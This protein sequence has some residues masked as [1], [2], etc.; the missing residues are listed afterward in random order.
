MITGIP[1]NRVLTAIVGILL[2]APLPLRAQD[3][4]TDF[5]RDW[6]FSKGEQPEAARELSFD[7]SSWQPVRLPH[8]WAISGPFD[9]KA[10][11]ST[12]KLPWQ[13]VGWYRKKF[14]V[15][16][17]EGQRVYF[18]F[19][20]VMAFPKVYVNG[21][22]AGEWDYGY[23]SFRVDTT[24]LIR[25][26]Q[27][28]VIA[29]EADTRRHRSRWYPGAGIYRKVQMTITEP[30]HFAHWG[31][32]VTTPAVSDRRA[33]IRVRSTIENHE[34]TDQEVT[35]EVSILD[36][37]G[38]SVSTSKKR[39]TVPAGGSAEVDQQMF[40]PDP[41]RWDIDHPNLYRA[42]ATIRV[43]DKTLGSQ[44]VTF[45]IRTFSFDANRGFFLNG[46]RV[47]L[48]GVDL[49]HDLGALG[50]AFNRRA[51]QRQLEI[52]KEMG[53]N[54]LRTSH[55]APAP[56]VLE[57]CDQ[58]GIFVWDECFDKWDAT[59]DNLG[60]PANVLPMA[61]RQL[62]NFVR[63]DRNHPCVFV[64][65]VGNEI[66]TSVDERGDG[67]S[68]G[69]LA[70]MRDAVRTQDDTRPVGI[71]CHTPNTVNYP[72]YDPLDLTGWNYG[73]RYARYREAYPDKPILYSESS[74]TVSTRGYYSLPLPESKTDYPGGTEHVS[75]YDLSATPW[76]DIPD[77]EFKLME[78]DRFVGGEFV[79]TGFDYL[80]EP[81]PNRRTARSSYFG[82]VDLAGIP[83]DRY[84]L[85]RS[86]WRPD[87]QT[88]HILPHWNWPERVGKKV[89]VFVYTDGDSGELFL[90]GKSLG[91][92]TKGVVPPKPKKDYYDV[93]YQYRLR[94]NDV[95]Y[96]PGEL[97]VVVY[98]KG[99]KVGEEV[100]RT[101]GPPASIRLTPDRTKLL[102]DGEDLSFILVEAMDAQGNPAPLADNMIE[103]EVAGAGE[104]AAADNGDQLSLESFQ[105]NHHALFN[106]KAMLIVRTKDSQ[107][108]P[109]RV[110]A[111]S[112]GLKPAT[113]SLQTMT[114]AHG[115]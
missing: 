5:N 102:A 68:F 44:T 81:T 109:I 58:M 110:T 55:N 1:V 65:S 22:L 72:V 100:M 61:V 111:R 62:N 53:V 106:G 20:G 48:H 46:R 112:A 40:V 96:E 37:K 92:R 74:S 10:S 26:G 33:T 90:N 12:G 77:V 57:L 36:P 56:E 24:P 108:G 14:T 11:G 7:D 25:F 76:S 88:I 85:Y 15:E 64:W 83:K 69:R 93:T 13:G 101:A 32:F 41:Q 38:S 104:L 49:H 17:H 95:I 84:Y 67:M 94:W 105:S 3:A 27:Q 80:G 42:V 87:V 52:M 79:W 31:I 91:M 47:Q 23:M 29:V 113:V 50:A 45:G 86:H 39:G 107:V 16:G 75:S 28:N 78:D 103:F 4:V 89:P 18:D 115:N 99:V 9:A 82:I 66:G 98:K 19:D 6:R 60:G 30:V 97:K 71:A 54:A 8:D 59:A 114:P 35:I 63:R 73:R 70:G 2:L 21:K 43:G 51:M 34:S